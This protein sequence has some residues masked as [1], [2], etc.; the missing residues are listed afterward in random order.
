MYGNHNGYSLEVVYDRIEEICDELDAE[1]ISAEKLLKF[2]TGV[3]FSNSL[4]H[5]WTEPKK[6]ANFLRII[7]AFKNNYA[8]AERHTLLEVFDK[9]LKSD[10]IK[11]AITE[12]VTVLA[13]SQP[14]DRIRAKLFHYIIEIILFGYQSHLTQIEDYELDVYKLVS[15]LKFKDALLDMTRDKFLQ[16]E[17]IYMDLQKLKVQNAQ[18]KAKIQFGNRKFAGNK[19]FPPQNY[20]CLSLIPS[21]EELNIEFEPYLRSA[22]IDEPY[23]DTEHYLDVHFR[24]LRED[25]I[26]PLR[27][28]IEEIK[29]G[30]ARMCLYKNVKILEVALHLSSGEYIHYAK[31]HESQHKL[32]IKTLKN[33]SL[34]C[35]S[36]DKYQNEFFF[37]SVMDREDCLLYD[38]KIGI[39]FENPYEIDM[40]KEYQ[41]VESPAYFEAYRHVLTALQNIPPGEPLPF[42]KYLIHGQRETQRPKH[43]NGWNLYDFSCI[44]TYKAMAELA[45]TRYSIDEIKELSIE[46]F[47]L[48]PSQ[49]NAFTYALESEIALIQGP[50]GT[51]KSYV[52]LQLAKFLLNETNW[53]QWNR[54]D[55]PL[56]IV[57]YTNH[58]LDQFLKGICDFADDKIVRVGS[59]SQDRVLIKYMMHQWR[60]QFSNKSHRTIIGH[61]KR[62]EAEI[63]K[64]RRHLKQLS[65]GLACREAMLFSSDKEFYTDDIFINW[66]TLWTP[67]SKK[68]YQLNVEVIRQLVCKGAKEEMA[69]EAYASACTKKKKMDEIDDI[70][71][72]VNDLYRQIKRRNF[73]IGMYPCYTR[74]WPF[75]QD[76]DEVMKLGYS[77]KVAITLLQNAKMNVEI[78]KEE[79]KRFPVKLPE[80][81]FQYYDSDYEEISDDEDDLI[82]Q[83]KKDE[84]KERLKQERKL[85]EEVEEFGK[86]IRSV[87][88]M[89]E[90]ERK[91]VTDIWKIPL[92]ARWRLYQ[93]W[94]SEAKV[95]TLGSLKEHEE[96][97][98][99]YK[100]QVNELNKSL[101]KVILQNAKVIGMTTTGAAKYQ[102]YLEELRPAIVIA[103]EAAEVLEAHIFTSLTSSC[104][105]LILIG[106]HQ[107][108]RPNIADYK[109]IDYHFDVSL[110][111]K[112]VQSGCSHRMLSTQHRMRPEISSMMQKHFY[113]DL[114]NSEIVLSRPHVKGLQKDVVYIQHEYPESYS[115]ED[116]SRKNVYE[117]NYSL[118]LAKYFLQQDYK[119]KQITILCTYS[120]QR[121]HLRR[122]AKTLFGDEKDYN[123]IIR[124]VNVDNYQGEECDIIILSLVRSK[125]DN[126]KIGYLNVKN[127]ICVA[128]SRARIGMYVIGNIEYLASAASSSLWS[129]I[130]ETVESDGNFSEYLITKCQIHGTEQIIKHWKDFGYKCPDGGCQE[131]CDAVLGCGHKCSLF[132]HAYDM[133]HLKIICEQP[134]P[135]VCYHN[136][137]CEKLCHEQCE[138]C[139]LCEDGNCYD[140]SSDIDDLNEVLPNLEIKEERAQEEYSR[141]SEISFFL[142]GERPKFRK[143]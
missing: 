71:A 133:E 83:A 29:T 70:I 121:F 123:K 136:V 76:I 135:K 103:E 24:L 55:T 54:Y 75:I 42:A 96:H 58:A 23:V 138:P 128:L 34:L 74:N 50:P 100:S 88:E 85:P 101:D 115:E 9:V 80:D 1:S 20:R 142:D 114:L 129:N 104:Q 141:N 134:C 112:L 8:A 21:P 93:F 57:C 4:L 37:A 111:E 40:I 18:K 51:G 81:P 13:D 3:T 78:I 30:K 72:V 98:F 63:V 25:L 143:K 19:G 68:V 36:S 15:T 106:D 39:K 84:E 48:N 27:T 113:E 64:Y 124:I 132:C 5:P 2:V 66:L 137:P 89:K 69:R 32:C 17:K 11:T 130:K 7:V 139:E 90:D 92:Q 95:L 97:Y 117:I 131:K 109:L 125:S 61:V 59:R 118:S 49:F 26:S 14:K 52:G 122:A 107:Q 46:N 120:D 79:C 77:E 10:L 41:M 43:S 86:Y 33:F 67:N 73:Y 110:F 16:L 119:P 82:K 102:S 126:N 28:G 65:S 22:K 44:F 38:G 45:T 99:Y 116:E 94:V 53:Q 62:L 87:P 35:L 127:R 108:L 6:L 56:L 60:K 91:E 12:N 31:I 105:H 47:I 140:K